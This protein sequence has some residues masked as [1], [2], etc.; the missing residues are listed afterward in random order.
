MGACFA[1]IV[2]DIRH[3]RSPILLPSLVGPDVMKQSKITDYEIE[4]VK[5]LALEKL[6]RQRNPKESFALDLLEKQFSH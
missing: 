4:I 3:K 1:T 2:E 5:N 6:H